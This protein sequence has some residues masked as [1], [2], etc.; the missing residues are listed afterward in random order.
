MQEQTLTPLKSGCYD[1]WVSNKI[2]RGKMKKFCGAFAALFV[3]FGLSTSSASTF[4]PPPYGNKE[5]NVWVGFG[6]GGGF[7]TSARVF[8]KHFGKHLPDNPVVVV[9]NKQ[10]AGSVKLLNFLYRKT[11]KNRFDIGFFLP[12]AM[13][14][15]IYGKRKVRFKT[16]DFKYIGNM[17]TDIN[18]CSVWRGG[19]QGIETFNDLINAKNPIIFGSAHPSTP[20]STFPM[21]F[22]NVFGANIR[23]V[24]GYR[25]T[26]KALHAVMTGEVHGF[27]G[28]FESSLRG[29]FRKYHKA[30][31]LRPII[32]IDIKGKSGFFGEKA[33]RLSA[34]LKTEE[35]RR[36]ANFV[37]GI[38]RMTRP[39]IAPPHTS[40]ENLFILRKAFFNTMYDLEFQA[41]AKR[42]LGVTP[43][44]TDGWEVQKFFE[45]LANT[46]R[47]VVEKAWKIT[48][49]SK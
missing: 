19:G 16:E 1:E 25:G 27:C 5:V 10:G 41:D 40:K 28:T 39:I 15:P 24:Q 17:Y 42:I 29:P 36:L 9:R 8:A 23:I 47:S 31:D 38:D 4:T 2:K 34:L 21:F 33:T 13:H 3:C 6:P 7:D 46:P 18:S 32:Q 14:I 26:A 49:T 22:K 35:Q 37:F 20:M 12:T 43:N 45:D 30:G 11:P 48:Q 44:P